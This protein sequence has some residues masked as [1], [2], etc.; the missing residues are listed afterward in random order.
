M[1]GLCAIGGIM[2]YIKGRS[3]VSLVAGVGIGSIYF[4]AGHRIQK[5]Q[6]MGHD[7]ALGASTL[8]LCAMGPKAFRTRA[9]VPLVM[10]TLGTASAVYSAKKGY[11]EVYGV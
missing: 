2:G 8:L 4:F 11:E 5:N 10:T 7:I 1:A 6:S 3:V 9:P